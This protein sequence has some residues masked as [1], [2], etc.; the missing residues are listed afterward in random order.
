M[1]VGEM[2]VSGAGLADSS[3]ATDAAASIESLRARGAARFD[4]VGFCFIEALA[5]RAAAH[6]GGARRVIEHRLARAVADLNGRLDGA[7]RMNPPTPDRPPGESLLAELLA[8]VRRQSADVSS[9]GSGA[10]AGSAEPPTELKAMRYFRRTWSRLS[11]D[12][13]LSH[14]VAQAPENA[15]PLNSHFLALQA[16]KLMRDVSPE[17]LGQ[18]M[19][20]VDALLWL[21]RAEGSRATQPK[22]GTRGERERKRKS[23]R[24][25]AG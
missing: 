24:A 7:E 2:Q 23:G 25:G 5:R 6:R 21:D 9:N 15:G 12:H 4:A 1:R 14:A 20:Y 10:V 22:A 18:F 16:L 19:S 17:C 3:A 13:Q 8:H 11:V